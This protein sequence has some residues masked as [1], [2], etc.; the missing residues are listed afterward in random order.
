MSTNSNPPGSAPPPYG[1]QNYT[2]FPIAGPSKTPSGFLDQN[3]WTNP[4][5]QPQND[6]LGHD[7]SHND[8]GDYGGDAED[9]DQDQDQDVSQAIV[10]ALPRSAIKGVFL[11]AGDYYIQGKTPQTPL[12]SI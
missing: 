1:Y 10:L 12:V 11:N 9:N 6:S 2:T 8:A 5:D 7:V 4:S 3:Q